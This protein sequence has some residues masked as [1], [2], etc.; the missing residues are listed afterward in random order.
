M[1]ARYRISKLLL[2]LGI[3]WVGGQA[4]TGCHNVWLRSERFD[5][6]GRQLAFDAAIRRRC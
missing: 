6:P 5:L 4:R 3:V 1:R 2:Q